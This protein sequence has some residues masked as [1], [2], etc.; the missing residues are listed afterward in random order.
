MGV[1]VSSVLLVLFSRP[2]AN[3][4][5]DRE[6]LDTLLVTPA[7]TCCMELRKLILAHS[8]FVCDILF[9]MILI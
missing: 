7:T 5:G 6:R 1:V 9:T 2:K 4:F 8:Y 3:F